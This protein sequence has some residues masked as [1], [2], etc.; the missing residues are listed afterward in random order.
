MNI[1]ITLTLDQEQS[2]ALQERVDLYNAGSGLP[3]ITT[4]DFLKTVQ[5]Q[6]Y[7]KTLVDQRYAASLT[8]LGASAASL[9]YEDRQ[10]LIAQ[11]EAQLP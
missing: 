11:I 5:L 7:I 10:D 9:S 6:P 2:D 8:R 4:D 1:S 3:A